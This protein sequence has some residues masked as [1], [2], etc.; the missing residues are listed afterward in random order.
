MAD[1]RMW[2]YPELRFIAVNLYKMDYEELASEVNKKFHEGVAIR[3][4]SDVQRV[5]KGKNIFNK[6]KD[7]R[8]V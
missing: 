1:R 3:T 4:S 7:R 6:G 5:G 8:Q 2:T